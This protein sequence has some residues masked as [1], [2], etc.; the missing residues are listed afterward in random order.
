MFITM[1]LS[2][3]DQ[4]LEKIE[5][6]L[7]RISDENVWEK[8]K[9]GTNS[10]GNLCLHLAGNEYHNIVSSIGGHPFTRERSAEFLAE[11]GYSCK[12]LYSRLA[13]VRE[14]SRSILTALTEEELDR[15]VTVQYPPD[16][17]IATYNRPISR[18]LYHLTVHY[19]YHTGQIVYMTRLLQEQDNNI[20]KWKH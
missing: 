20:L 15:E 19:G 8:L 11:G 17:G 5:K 3:L 13:N 14:Q 7:T 6:A 2:L 4:E 18:L 12:E 16:A 10:I 9:E 1:T